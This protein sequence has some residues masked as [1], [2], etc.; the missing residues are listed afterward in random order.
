MVK[1]SFLMK[2]TCGMGLKSIVSPKIWV[3]I[4]GAQGKRIV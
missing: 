4:L 1:E 2:V 3:K